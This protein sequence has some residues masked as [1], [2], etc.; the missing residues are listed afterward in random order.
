MELVWL[1]LLLKLMLM[2]Q[3]LLHGRNFAEIVL[4][5]CCVEAKGDASVVLPR[6]PASGAGIAFQRRQWLLLLLLSLLMLLLSQGIDKS[7]SHG[8]RVGV[9]MGRS[10]GEMRH[11]GNR[12]MQAL[13]L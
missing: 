11:G 8:R 5:G 1:S 10:E 9:R 6:T 7:G 3:M 4:M 2:R 12:M 13:I